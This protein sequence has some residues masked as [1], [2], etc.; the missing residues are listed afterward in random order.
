[1]CQWSGDQHAIVEFTQDAVVNLQACFCE[2]YTVVIVGIWGG[3]HSDDDRHCFGFSL[4]TASF[5][6][7]IPLWWLCFGSEWSEILLV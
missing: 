6:L 5:L 4:K 1:M 2:V 7:H 3:E